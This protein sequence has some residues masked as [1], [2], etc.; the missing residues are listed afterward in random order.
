[1]FE[2]WSI[3]KL[4]YQ[5]QTRIE[6][7]WHGKQS[8]SR[9]YTYVPATDPQGLK[10]HA[11]HKIDPNLGDVSVA[12]TAPI[13][14]TNSTQNVDTMIMHPYRCRYFATGHQF[15][16]YCSTTGTLCFI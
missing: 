14:R 15:R 6:A 5:S 4:G 11:S 1:M 10:Q 13:Q 2:S 9:I 16:Q 7:K 12:G 3:T 8:T